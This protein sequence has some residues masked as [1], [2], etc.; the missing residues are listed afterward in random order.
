M[1]IGL[2]ADTHLYGDGASLGHEIAQ[3][4]AGVDLILHAGDV[5]VRGVLDWLEGIAPVLC[6]RGN[7]DGVLAQ[8]PRVKPAHVLDLE[9]LRLGLIHSLDWPEPWWRPLEEVMQSDFGGTVDIIVFGDSHVAVME[10]CKGVL[11]VNPGSTT[12]PNGLMNTPGTVGLLEVA[13]GQA[14]ARLIRLSQVIR[15]SSP[16]RPSRRH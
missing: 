4:F 7:G 13:G 10:N 14:Q 8:D 15:A 2:I 6:A 5:Y 9:G 1:K 3:V 11:L 12:F 16:P